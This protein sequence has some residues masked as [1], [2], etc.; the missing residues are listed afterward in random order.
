[1]PN[2]LERDLA[3]LEQAT[4]DYFDA[5]QAAPPGT[6]RQRKKTQTKKDL[7]Q[8]TL[9]GMPDPQDAAA[10]TTKEHLKILHRR[11]DAEVLRLYDLPA[12]LE[13]KVLDLFSGVR[14]RGVPF[15]QTGYFPKDFT[16]LDRL[17]DLL[18]V[19]VDWPKTNR[20]R[21]KLIDLEEDRRLTPQQADEL[22]NLQRLADARIS[23]LRPVQ[24]E[25]A[26]KLIENLKRRGL[27]QE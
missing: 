8:K 14:R 21:A 11:I 17:S 6:T 25:G 4:A 9:V 23:L 18:A 2:L 7:R 27:W 5:A 22:E 1:M 10:D 12:P 19:T 3:A 13:R 24:I 20:R 16:E 15:E 26:D